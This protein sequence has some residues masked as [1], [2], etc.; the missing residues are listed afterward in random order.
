MTEKIHK[1]AMQAYA[2][3]QRAEY[4]EWQPNDISELLVADMNGVFIEFA[5]LVAKDCAMIAYQTSDIDGDCCAS[6]ILY[7]YNVD[8]CRSDK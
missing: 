5:K 2:S 3:E 1:L 6:S 8:N 7:E 4:V